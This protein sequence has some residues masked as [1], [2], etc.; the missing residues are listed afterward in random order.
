MC[1]LNNRVCFPFRSPGLSVEQRFLLFLR[2]VSHWTIYSRWVPIGGMGSC[3]V[4]RN[5]HLQMYSLCFK[6]INSFQNLGYH[7]WIQLDCLGSFPLR[8]SVGEEVERCPNSLGISSSKL[9]VQG[10]WVFGC[11]L[12][13]LR[14]SSPCSER[15]ILISR[16]AVLGAD[17]VGR[18]RSEP[19]PQDVTEFPLLWL[20]SL[21][22]ACC[23]SSLSKLP[24]NVP[25]AGTLLSLAACSTLSG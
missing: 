18:S 6:G 24:R 16:S 14:K 1:F 20:S 10:Q 9:W 17:C 12:I 7:C 5:G 13:A 21:L 2:Q 22:P 15:S 11:F 19:Q 3:T 4:P 23:L 25:S 8:A